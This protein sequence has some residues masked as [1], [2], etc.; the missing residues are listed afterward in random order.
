MHALSASS[1]EEG[2]PQRQDWLTGGVG[3]N[4][5]SVQLFFTEICFYPETTILLQFITKNSYDNL[6]YAR[7][8][9]E[10]VGQSAC[11]GSKVA[12]TMRLSQTET[13]AVLVSAS[14]KTRPCL[15]KCQLGVTSV[16]KK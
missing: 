14:S 6:D 9:P 8:R 10:R 16:I 13:R 11:S 5:N 3:L 7:I 4:M 2:Q 15:K 12:N 1:E